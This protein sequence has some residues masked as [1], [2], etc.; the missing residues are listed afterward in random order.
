MHRT[1]HPARRLLAQ[2][3]APFTVQVVAGAAGPD[4]VLGLD[5]RVADST[6]TRELA[7]I[8]ARRRDLRRRV[9]ALRDAPDVAARREAVL[10]VERKLEIALRRSPDL[11]DTLW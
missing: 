7:T 1:S 11:V 6:V 10:A 3:L 8:V 2:H 9:E 5:N 4:G